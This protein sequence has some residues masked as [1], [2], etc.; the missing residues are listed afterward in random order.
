MTIGSP[1]TVAEDAGNVSFTVL[2]RVSPNKMVPV[3]YDVE[4]SSNG[5]GDFITTANEGTA[6]TD[7]GKSATLDFTSE[8]NCCVNYRRIG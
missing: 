2:A 3:N 1:S 8:K 5:N 7:T 4:E 6:A